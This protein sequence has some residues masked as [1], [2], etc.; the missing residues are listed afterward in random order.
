M[1]EL[2][3]NNSLI[4]EY[5]NFKFQN[6]YNANKTR[7]LLKYIQTFSIRN[8]HPLVTDPSMQMQLNNDPLIDII[9][10]CSD[11]DL[12]KN[13]SLKLMLVD[14]YV[15]T[16]YTVV[17]IQNSYEKIK[18]RF[19]G[20][21]TGSLDKNNAQ[22]HIKAL[23]SDA[24]YIIIYD[25][26]INADNNQWAENKSIIQSIVP[27]VDINLKIESGSVR[28]HKPAL[29]NDEKLELNSICSLWNIQSNQ[30]NDNSFHD[31]YIESDKVKI[32]LSGGIYNISTNSN[33]DFTYV[34]EIK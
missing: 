8:D 30:Y 3:L 31:R 20:T 25:S 1:A 5:L 19:G 22:K 11:D 28:N 7:K 17:N 21:Y 2:A 29:T 14:S 6:N 18:L 32:L 10:S 33:K 4:S 12:V 9:Q 13:S 24:S 23:L 27:Q 26:Y 15:N 16:S 34:V